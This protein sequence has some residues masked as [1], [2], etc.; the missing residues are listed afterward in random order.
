MAKAKES[1]AADAPLELNAAQR[2]AVEHG[3]GPLLVVAGAG[4]GKTRVI[5]ERIRR[6][7]ETQTEIS[8]ENILGLTFTEKAAAEMKHRVEKAVGER[9]KGLT[10]TTFHAFCF[11]L[12]KEVNPGVQVLDQTDHWI[13][14]RRNLPRLRLNLYKR[15]AE[16]GQFLGDFAQFFSRCQD[17]LVEPADYE[18]YVAGLHK[19]HE[20]MKADLDAGERAEREAELERQTELARVY[21]VS[22]AL[23]RERNLITFGG[24]LL[25]AVKLLRTNAALLEK[26]RERYHYILVDEFQDTNIAQIELLWLLGRAHKNIFVVGDDD[27][28]IYRFRGASFGSFQQFAE[29]FIGARPPTAGDLPPGDLPLGDLLLGD[30]P[31]GDLPVAPTVENEKRHVLPLLENYRSTKKV[32]RV[33]GQVIAQ[34]AD[35]YIADKQLETQNAE[36]DKIQ[37]VELG[38]ADDEANWVAGEVERLY[39]KGHRWGEFAVLYRMHTHREK[40]VKVLSARKIPFVIK[41]LSILTNPLVRDVLAYLRLI[42]TPSDDVACA[43][44]LG[45]PAWGFEAQDLARLCARASKNRRQP[46]WDALQGAQGEL[47]FAKVGR[48]TIE[49]IEFIKR[50]RGRAWKLRASELLDELIAEL[51]LVLPED[52]RNRP[53]LVR[54]GDFVREWEQKALTETGKLAELAQYLDDFAAA[55]GQINLAE[56]GGR[57]AVHLM[58]VHAA[59]GLEFDHV[60]VLRLV[61]GGFPARPRQPVL[62]FPDALMKEES[63]QGDFQIQEER[64]LFYV[65]LTRARKRLTLTTVIHKRSRRSEFLEDFLSAPEIQ[66]NDVQQIA[67]KYSAPAERRSGAGEGQLFGAG[68]PDSRAYSRIAQWA[69][70]FHPPAPL[71]LQLSATAIE[72]YNTCPQRFLF[73]HIWGLRGGP[74]AATT[75]GSVMHTTVRLVLKEWKENKR[76]LPWDEVEMIFRREWRS[77]GF[78]DDYQEKEYQ[79]EGLEQLREFHAGALPRPEDVLG[80]EKYFELPMEGNVVVTGRMDQV[81]RLGPGEAEIVDYK[82]GRPKDEKAARNSLQLSIYALAARGVLELDPVRL[83]FYNLMTNLPVCSTRDDKQLKKAEEK[84]QE[85]A[86]SIRAGEFGASPGFVCRTCEYRPVCPAHEGSG[87]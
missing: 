33:S 48:R 60:F 27:Q 79:R 67:P 3:E 1:R 8:G 65:A 7:L 54:L 71:P 55:N 13:L 43:R 74:R 83:T 10:L 23:L 11:S 2:R 4:T 44:V 64:R 30:L 12:L 38:S 76:L 53:Y 80:Q 16:P 73:D 9:A 66:K 69:E 51:G 86:G 15:V 21:R 77:A 57:D 72:G 82:T 19:A 49:L 22:E 25:E 20:E 5:T 36:G 39:D 31:L 18:R 52:D 84:V 85:V 70:T 59:K 68:D 63:P 47:E 40:L 34:N 81:N 87:E 17:E 45:A 6:L 75:F 58:T 46:L 42:A 61:M 28:A 37:V 24:Q 35:R 14:M 26:L 62:E 32:L 50:L 29:R 41:N 56:S 78:E